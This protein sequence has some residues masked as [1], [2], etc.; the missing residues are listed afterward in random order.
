LA[1]L[2]TGISP[3]AF[4]RSAVRTSIWRDYDSR[5]MNGKTVGSPIS[6]DSRERPQG[7]AHHA[8]SEAFPDKAG[9]DEHIAG[10]ATAALS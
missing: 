7:G 9:G 3:V 6:S 8:R 5:R 1:S 2:S 4:A 10:G